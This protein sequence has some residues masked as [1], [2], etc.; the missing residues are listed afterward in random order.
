MTSKHRKLKKRIR[1]LEQ[2]LVALEH[3]IWQHSPPAIM[4]A[5][6]DATALWAEAVADYDTGVDAWEDD[7][8]EIPQRNGYL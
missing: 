6:F 7:W 2:R 4:P 8:D 1:Q 5:E 3:S